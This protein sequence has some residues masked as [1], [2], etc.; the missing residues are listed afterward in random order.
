MGKSL[1]RQDVLVRTRSGFVMRVPSLRESI[2]FCLY[3]DGEYEPENLAFILRH[4]PDGVFLDIGANIGCFSVPVAK[5]LGKTGK[6]IAVEASPKIVPFLKSNLENNGIGNAEIIPFAASDRD[7]GEVPFFEPPSRRFG[8]GS[9]AEQFGVEP[10]R[11]PTRTLDSIVR[12]RRIS[13]VKVIK[14]DVEGYEKLV[15]QGAAGLLSGPQ[16][17]LLIFEFA[18]WAETRAGFRAGEAQELLLSWGY[19]LWE[20]EGLLRGNPP[21]SEP[22][23]AG[24]RTVVAKRTGGAS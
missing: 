9:M 21:L 5:A 4:C 16:A 12:E 3:V 7:G 15:F 24:F 20:L 17:P 23:R 22:L 1:D 6:V 18:D 11:V 13:D 2:G 8:M 10:V 19:S 14:V